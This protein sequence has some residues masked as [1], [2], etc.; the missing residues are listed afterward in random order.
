[1]TYEIWTLALKTKKL[2]RYCCTFFS[3]T[4]HLL[5]VSSHLIVPPLGWTDIIQ[6][7]NRTYLASKK[8]DKHLSMDWLSWYRHFCVIFMRKLAKP[9]AG[10]RMENPKTAFEDRLKN[11]ITG[12]LTFHRIFH[13][14]AC[15]GFWLIFS[16]KL[17]KNVAYSPPS[18]Y[19]NQCWLLTIGPLGTNF[20]FDIFFHLRL[21]NR[22]VGDLRRIRAHYD[23]T[24]I[25]SD[26]CIATNWLSHNNNQS[27][28]I[29]AN[30]ALLGSLLL[31]DRDHSMNRY[32]RVM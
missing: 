7:W 20:S 3:N 4:I 24:V 30:V 23:F 15:R 32:N 9:S 25:I 11:N 27:V 2:W 8:E 18:Y 19:L 29:H 5:P 13:F 1:M 17:H 26:S 12:T 10:K 31:T 16:L 21:N 28:Y 22:D 14:L 6:Y